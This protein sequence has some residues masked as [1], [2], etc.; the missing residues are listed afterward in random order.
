MIAAEFAVYL[1]T[2][3]AA[4]DIADHVFGQTD[5]I[6]HDKVLDGWIAW[7][8]ILQHVTAYHIVMAIMLVAAIILANLTITPLGFMLGIAFSAISHAII[9]RR[10]PI[11]WLLENTGSPKFAQMQTPI[12]GMYQADQS[13]HKLCLWVSAFL[14][15]L[16]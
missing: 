1:L 4:H 7:K 14:A 15:V 10:W 13:S 8:A 9:D 5:K 12:C 6:A 16:V 3:Y 11:R 2:M